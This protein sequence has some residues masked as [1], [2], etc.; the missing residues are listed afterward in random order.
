[1]KKV[2]VVISYTGNNFGAYV[3]SLLGCV[4]TG[5]S[6]EE[7]MKN[8]KEAI[9]FHIESSLEDYDPIDDVFKNKFEIAY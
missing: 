9:D 1:M 3:P 5:N 4:A 7:V 6:L 8:I 2:E